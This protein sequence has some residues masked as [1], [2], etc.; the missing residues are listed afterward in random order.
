MGFMHSSTELQPLAEQHVLIYAEC[1]NLAK[2]YAAIWRASL[3]LSTMTACMGIG[4]Y[5]STTV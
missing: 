4:S 3:L 5:T 2:Q 1:L